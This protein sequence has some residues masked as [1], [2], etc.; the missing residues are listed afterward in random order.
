MGGGG[1]R[2]GERE[3][4]MNVRNGEFETGKRGVRGRESGERSVNRREAEREM[5]TV[6]E[7]RKIICHTRQEFKFLG[8]KHTE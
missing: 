5:N 7:R 1:G 2:W 6:R 3:K 4:K 8:W